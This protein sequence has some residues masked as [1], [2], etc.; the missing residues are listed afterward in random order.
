LGFKE[1]P[2]DAE[3]LTGRIKGADFAGPSEWQAFVFNF[4]IEKPTFIGI[5]VNVGNSTDVYF[6]SLN[7][8]Q[9]SGGS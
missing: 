5:D 7:V 4:A 6:Y 3:I 9:V 2:E 1:K 8:L